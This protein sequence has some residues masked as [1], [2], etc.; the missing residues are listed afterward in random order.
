MTTINRSALL[1]YS[2]S[3]LFDLVCDI[4]AYPQFMDG[5]AGAEVLRRDAGVIEARLD[6]AKGGIR[7]SFS[8]RNALVPN[9][10]MTLELI[11][12]PFDSFAG[13]W[14]FQV[15]GDAGAKLSLHLEFAF[16]NAVLGAAAS[17]LF[18]KVT[19][20]L[21]DAVGQRAQQVYG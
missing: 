10:S 5:C 9:E 11:D 13:R 8:T 12:G 14:D 18:D 21:V 17:R 15:L 2:A 1:P 19:G 7:Q 16:N 6:L 20:N 4:E 3:Q